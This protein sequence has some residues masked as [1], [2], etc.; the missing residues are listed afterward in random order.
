MI[1]LLLLAA[2]SFAQDDDLILSPAN[3]P[4]TV[5]TA[6]TAGACQKTSKKATQFCDNEDDCYAFCSCA[7]ALDLENWSTSC[8][9]IPSKGPA[10][11]DPKTTVAVPAMSYVLKSG[12]PKAI[13]S[14]IDELKRLDTLMADAAERERIW[15]A[16]NPTDAFID[17]KI[18]V[19][20]CYR[21]TYADTKADCDIILKANQ[22]V[23]NGKEDPKEAQ[24]KLW[25]NP[26]YAGLAWPGASPHSVGFACDIV[27]ATEV[28]VEKKVKGKL[29]KKTVADKCFDC[30]AGDGKSDESCSID[31]K[32]ASK[33]LDQWLDKVGA[34]RLDYEAWHYEWR[35]DVP[36]S[37][38]QA[39]SC[40]IYPLT[41]KP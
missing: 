11:N 16:V 12:S 41:C 7:C 14:V 8:D 24:W 20:S 10:E 9:N 23:N 38:C 25:R 4:Q 34:L 5:T 31:Q 3:A 33:I 35:D 30:H 22:V 6:K 18:M 29:V 40:T 13:Q 32:T 2:L 26:N 27:L 19:N 37:R 36:A 15:K 28:E 39:G 1:L 17:Y 21:S